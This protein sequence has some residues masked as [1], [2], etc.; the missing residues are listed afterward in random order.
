MTTTLVDNIGLLVTN[1]PGN[2]DESPLGVVR[3][4]AMVIEAER[5]VWVG[6]RAHAPAADARVDLD[7]QTVVPGFVDS[8]SHLIF[9]S[10]RADEFA[11]RMAGTPYTAGGI[12]ATLIATREASDDT[13]R[14][15]ASRLLAEMVSSG[16]TTVEIKSGYGLTTDDE[17]RGVAI[18]Q[19]LTPESTFLGAHVV[20]VEYQGRRDDYVALVAGPMLD[21]CAAG[22]RWIDVFCDRGAFSVDEARTILQAGVARG[23][24][25]R[26]HAHQLERTGAVQLGVEIDAASVDHCNHMTDADVEALAGS[27]TVATV[28]PGADFSTRS[29]YADARRLIDAGVVV[30]LATDCNPGSSYTTSMP[31]CIAVAVR[32]MHM[33]PAEAL[34]A[35]TAGGAR[36]LRRDDIGVL[37][38]GKR[39][40]FA[41]IAAPSYVHL[42]YRPGVA[43]V[44]ATWKSVP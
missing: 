4:A 14:S 3:D 13:L 19:A 29:V 41:V 6:R 35:A 42:A 43:L 1:D 25:P 9:A 12:A 28:L 33:T 44:T 10:D 27:A 37:A 40:D 16:T 39:A 11:S 38:V 30:A 26:L 23:L 34:W 15:N 8:H 21:A 18:A 20:P 32:D 36:A 22:T 17:V 5:V 7:R 31:F 2:G 24:L